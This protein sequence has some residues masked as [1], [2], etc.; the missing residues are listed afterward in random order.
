MKHFKTYLGSFSYSF[1]VGLSFLVTKVV[2][3]QAES[4]L[5]LAHRF[6]IAFIG[7]SIYIL[8]TNK[9]DMINLTTRTII[10]MLPILI[11][12]PLLFFG[13][14]VFGLKT[15]T[16]SEGGIIFAT[17]P[18]ITLVIG[19]L[20]G[21]KPSRYQVI[22]MILSVSGLIIIFSNNLFSQT[23][24]T[25]GI[26]LL[27]M[28]ALSFSIYMI[29]VKNMLSK[30]NI[31]ELTLM[32]SVSGLLGF[33]LLY[34]LNQPNIT[35]GLIAYLVPFESISYSLSL[36]YL[37]I[38]AS[39]VASFSSNYALQ[40]I[41]ASRFSVFSNLSTLISIL[42][43]AIILNEALSI[44]HFIGIPLILAGII[45]T[46]LPRCLVLLKRK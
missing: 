16:S 46:N 22:C 42:A 23:A 26:L 39:I 15:T 9:K 29:M 20:L 1:F 37:G 40:Y 3:D 28:S 21:N 19:R 14:Q 32:I 38:F 35:L 36:I 5:I 6:L 45:G 27:F 44:R 31:Y 24:N 13:F 34:F 8:A 43:G 4:L 41:S 7:F 11:F 25:I 18:I 2:V 12:Y 30:T 33:N 17:V 10:S